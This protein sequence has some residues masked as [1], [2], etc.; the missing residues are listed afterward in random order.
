MI[1]MGLLIRVWRYFRGCMTL[2]KYKI[3]FGSRFKFKWS[4]RVRPS[5][6]IR[7][8]GNGKVQLGERVFLNENVIINSTGGEIF[9]EDD[10]FLNDM[11]CLNSRDKMIIGEKTIIGQGVKF[12]D[13]DHDYQQNLQHDFKCAPIIVGKSVWI[14]ADV[15]L[16]KGS[17]IGNRSVIGAATLVN[18]KIPDKVVYI[19]KRIKQMYK[20]RY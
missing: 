19:N 7:I 18:E 11:V 6:I 8:N 4:C 12:Y 10:V 2:L 15:I 1:I 3:I 13:H 14:G 20:I 16:L 5:L 17:N 9:L